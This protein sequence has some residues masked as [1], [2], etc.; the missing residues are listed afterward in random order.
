MITEIADLRV[1]PGTQ[2]TFVVALKRGLDTVLSKSPGYVSHQIQHCI[3]S[4]ERY[5]LLITWET[6]EDHTVGFRQSEAYAEWRSIVGPFFVQPP[7][8]E[9]FEAL[10]SK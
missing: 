2:K 9:H 7:I 10:V 4:P 3:E 8:V 1:A 5:L 6:L